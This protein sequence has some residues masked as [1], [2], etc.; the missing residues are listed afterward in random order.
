[1]KILHW[2]FVVLIALMAITAGLAKVFQIPDEVQ[3]LN[4]FGFTT[5]L[6][7]SYGVIQTIG[8]VLILVPRTL[9]I[10]AFVTALAFILSSVLILLSG[11]LIFSLV[12]LIPVMLTYFIV[13]S[14][15]KISQ[16]NEVEPSEELT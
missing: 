5:L 4:L 8:G 15:I 2:L 11:D 14:S 16:V 10:G 12:S 3:F 1:M 13:W 9:K 7:V 6:I